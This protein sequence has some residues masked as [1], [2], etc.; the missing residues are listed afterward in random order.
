[1]SPRILLVDDHAVVR[2]GV[3]QLLLDRGIASEVTEAQTGA[4]GLAAVAQHACDV[5]LLDISLPD[6]NGVEVLKRMKRKAP[7]IPVLMFS[8]YREDQY[9]VRAL[10]AGAAGYLSKTVDAAGMIAAIQQ[11]AGGRKYVSPAM[12]EALA[13]YVSV[14]GEQ[15]P[16]EKLSDREYQTLCMLASGQRL[17]DIA[18]TLSLSVKTVSV[19]RTRV[20]EKM[21]L[22]NN[23]ELT[24]YVMSN[25]LIDLNPA[26]TA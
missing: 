1:M 9:A 25:R 10:K 17:T 18:R 11:V 19:Y 7:R 12:A 6:M 23:A 13:D 4:E 22:S 21:K 8:M 14:D 16:H 15:L 5:V 26:M 2:Q 3:R 24:F 20:L